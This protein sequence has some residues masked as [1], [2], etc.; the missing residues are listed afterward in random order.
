MLKTERDTP[1]MRDRILAAAK[2]RFSGND[3]Q[4]GFP[5]F[6]PSAFYEHGQWWIENPETGAVWSVVD[7]EGGNAIDGFDFEPIG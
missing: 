3:E 7:A 1:A 5:F 2:A 6:A 4:E